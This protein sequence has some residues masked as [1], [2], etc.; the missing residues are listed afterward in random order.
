[1]SGLINS[2]GSK[3]GIIGTTELDYEE[4]T[5]T[6]TMY[7]QNGS[8]TLHG[9][10]GQNLCRY[11]KIGRTVSVQGKLKADSDTTAV[12]GQVAILGLPFTI[13]NNIE[14]DFGV[15]VV[16]QVTTGTTAGIF[17]ARAWL[18]YPKFLMGDRRYNSDYLDDIGDH[19]LASN[20]TIYF[21][22]TYTI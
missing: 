12:A 21:Q 1:M 6:A 15:H 20:T 8:I 18:G 22:A 10:N 13:Q 19:W 9:T 4:G 2:A 5:W 17:F 14:S 11:T 7:S 3:S 16:A